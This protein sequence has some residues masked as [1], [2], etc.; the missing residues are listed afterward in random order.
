VRLRQ[1]FRALRAAPGITIASIVILA[2]GIGAS[3]A[4]FSVVNGL[5]LRPLPVFDQDR[6]VRIW[7]N[8]VERGFFHDIVTYPEYLEWSRRSRQFESMAALWAWHTFDGILLESEEPR[9][10]QISLVSAN[11]FSVLGSSPDLGRTLRTED[12]GATTV[13]PL[14]LSHRAWKELFGA[15]PAVVGRTIPLRLAERTSFEVVGV[16]APSFDAGFGAMAWAPSLAVYPE[17]GEGQGC[18]CDLIGR[19]AAG[20]TAESARAEL[21][22]IHENLASERPDE[23]RLTEV[24]LTALL[25][26]VVGDAGRASVLAFVAA[27]LL[28]AISIANVAGLS[29]IRAFDRTS[30]MAI[31]SALGAGKALLLRERLTESAV[32]GGAALIGG[33]VVA[34]LGIE[35]LVVLKGTDLPRIQE[36]VIDSGALLFG[37]G[38]AVL[39]TALCASLSIVFGTPE[40]LRARG[41]ASQGRLMRAMVVGELALALPLL[42]ASALMVQTLF[43]SASIDRG[44]NARH[45]LTVESPLPPS[46]YPDPESRLAFFEEA[47]RRIEGLPGVESV[48]TLPLNPGAKLAGITGV[49][50]F[51]GQTVDEAR[52]NSWTN[53]EMVDP[54][55]FSVLEIPVIRGRAFSHFDRLSS[56]RVAIVSE[57]VAEI[58][59]RGQD[60]IGKT[61][62]TRQARSRVVGV[63]GDTR[64]RELMRPWPTVYFPMR[65]NPFSSEPS[66][67]PLLNQNG[68][69][70]RTRLPPESIAGAV[71]ASIRSRDPELVLRVAMMEELLNEDLRAP[72]FH[73]AFASSFSLIALLLAA[74]GVYSVFAAFVAQRLPELGV[75]SA[76]GA[77]PAR[78]RALV[79]KRGWNLVLAG[80][81]VGGIAAWWLSRFL[82]GFL[83]GVAPFD[84]PTLLGATVVLVTVSVAATAIPALR[85]GRVDPLILLK[86]E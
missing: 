85:A 17:W 46:K 81:T 21:Q 10:L 73:A 69:A 11:F 78:L 62:G 23:Y 72:K 76:L 39:T 38:I 28:L 22:A 49:F 26:S 44:F 52:D 16:M 25:Q 50:I 51:E 65:Q 36:V 5:L 34:H 61:F 66:L 82:S 48:T 40:S 77:T 57:E 14:V 86:Q 79:L 59:W 7:K 27:A 83:Y 37:A 43:A 42:F 9:R 75:R 63:V 41:F 47:V 54:S 6:L 32:I 71:T 31:R 1:A 80:I 67:H 35:T 30:E 56:E 8:D 29:L 12:E 13:P 74:A 19:L 58:Y 18:E 45:L 68:F 2:L 64:Y 24:V 3:T 55:Y 70:V 33:S 53:V 60:P 4:V 20:A 15:D 84:V